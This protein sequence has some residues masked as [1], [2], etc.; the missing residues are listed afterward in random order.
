LID[1]LAKTLME[2]EDQNLS[3]KLFGDGDELKKL[4]E[5]YIHCG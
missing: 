2:F 5:K 1:G 4:V 3:E